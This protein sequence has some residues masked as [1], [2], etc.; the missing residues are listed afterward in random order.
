MI[1]SEQIAMFNIPAQEGKN[2]R[3]CSLPGKL[4]T[5]CHQNLTARDLFAVGAKACVS[6]LLLKFFIVASVK[7]NFNAAVFVIIVCSKCAIFSEKS[8]VP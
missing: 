7:Y 3:D 4:R 8:S 1:Q 6:E 2:C 5:H